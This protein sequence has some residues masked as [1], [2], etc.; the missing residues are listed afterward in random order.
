MADGGGGEVVGFF[1]RGGL[2]V[3]AFGATVAQD[4]AG[5]AVVD[6]EMVEIGEQVAETLFGITVVTREQMDEGIEDDEA[7]VDAFNGGKEVGEIFRDGEDA[8]FGGREVRVLGKVGIGVG[9]EREDFDAVKVGPEVDEVLALGGVGIGKG[10]DDDNTALDRGGAVGHGLTRGDGGSDLEGEQAFA[11]AMIAIEQGDAAQ[12]ETLLPEP[13]D[14]LRG[15]GGAV[16]VV[17]C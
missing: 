5:D 10:G 3:A 13:R 9:D 2:G 1:E 8:C 16:G 11:Q 15:G 4:K 17:G 6:E 12:R 14:G 7:G